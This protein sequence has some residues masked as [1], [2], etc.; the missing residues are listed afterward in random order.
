LRR[1]LVAKRPDPIPFQKEGI[2]CPTLSVNLSEWR[3]QLKRKLLARD[4]VCRSC[5]EEFKQAPHMHEGI[6][7]RAEIQ[8]WPERWKKLIH[9]ELN[10]ALLCSDCNLGRSG[11]SPPDRYQIW[12][13]HREVYGNDTMRE[14]YM[15]LPL[16][17]RRSFG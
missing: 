10:C 2:L 9:C 8:K 14:W 1:S 5:G 17:V 13:E 7:S 12:I 11:K 15:S 3:K 4:V 6:V 16:R